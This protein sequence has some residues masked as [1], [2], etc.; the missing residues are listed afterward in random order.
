LT[1]GLFCVKLGVKLQS[2]GSF[3]ARV[4]TKAL[5]CVRVRKSFLSFSQRGID[6]SV[7]LW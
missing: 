6:K 4:L 5:P 2:D 1:K 7:T 3:S